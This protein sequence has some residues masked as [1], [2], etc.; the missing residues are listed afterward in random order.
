IALTLFAR[1]W[2]ATGLWRS[3]VVP[4]PS[5]PS[6]LSPQ[7]LTRPPL[8]SAQVRSPPAAILFTP[9]ARPETATGLW[10]SLVVPSPA[11]PQLLSPQHLTR[12]RLVRAQS[13]SP[14]AAIAFTPFARPGT[15][16]GVSRRA[17]VPSPS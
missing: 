9:F 8:V 12:P 10:W 11:S 2:T 15:P 14:P 13:C 5:S 1:S 17:V 4:S 6:S 3:F 7:H 16:T